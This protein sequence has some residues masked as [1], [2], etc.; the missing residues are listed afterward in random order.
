MDK[1]IVLKDM[2][3]PQ[4]EKLGQTIIFVRTREVARALHSAVRRRGPL[5]CLL[6]TCERT[7]SWA[8]SMQW[9]V[10]PFLA[11]EHAKRVPH[12]NVLWV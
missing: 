10:A 11:Q 1:V 4:C 3:F 12:A 6:C 9:E 8:M 7:N 5:P 2:I